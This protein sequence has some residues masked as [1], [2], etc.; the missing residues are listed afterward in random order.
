MA[1][2]SI[3]PAIAAAPPALVVPKAAARV[4][5]ARHVL[6][7]RTLV[8]DDD[9]TGSQAVHGLD[10]V[11]VTEPDLCCESLRSGP[12][13]VLTNT[14][15]LDEADAIDLT[16]GLV[17]GVDE[18]LGNP[19]GLRFVSRSD[20]T[21][22]GHLIAEIDVLRRERIRA[23]HAPY[24]GVLL[25]P[26]FFEA[27]RVT[28][29]D[30]H[31]AKVSGAFIGVGETEFARDATF[32]YSTSHLPTL[33]EERSAGAIRR[34]DVLS[35]SLEDI[36]EG[37]PE[38][39]AMI[40]RQATDGTWIIAN[41]L[42]YSDYD[43]VVLGVLEAEASGT[44]LAVRCGPS[45]VRSYLG[46]EA[47]PC[48]DPATLAWRANNRHRHGVVIVGSHTSV[49]TAQLDTVVEQ[50]QAPVLELDVAALLDDE[51]REA[52]LSVIADQASELLDESAVVISTTRTLV[53]GPDPQ[54]SL[55]I[56]RRVSAGLSEIL[57]R[58][59]QRRPGWV[60]AKGGITSHDLAVHG[61]GM[62]RAEVVG[63]VFPG[64]VSVF[65]PIE[66]TSDCHTVP[67]V[68]F[69]GNVGDPTSL[70]QV[71]ARLESKEAG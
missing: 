48:V 37:G 56:A 31:W 52:T 10:V 33:L 59:M 51:R 60:V 42:D 16:E 12:A 39:V 21:M 47:V 41:G 63:Q 1:T 62:T 71:V 9:P 65:R 53:A 20:S 6:G 19:A 61:L 46:I 66:A 58:L 57:R 43:I 50:C 27:G 22:R 44:A 28:A 35:I 32:G 55:A 29:N 68:V 70:A 8:L 24:G 4:R 7:L 54:S 23:G 13:F 3:P 64:Q 11:L 25:A 34:E 15:S 5:R 18:G 36:R 67:Y 26:A 17:R 69:P 45:F 30:H 49:T 14:R 38:R 2:A 40:C